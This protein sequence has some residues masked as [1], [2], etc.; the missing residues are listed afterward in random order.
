VGKIG[1]NANAAR[2]EIILAFQNRRGSFSRDAQLRL[3]DMIIFRKAWPDEIDRA[4]RICPERAKADHCFVAVDDSPVERIIGAAFWAVA[5]VS[6]QRTGATAQVEIAEFV[7]RMLPAHGGSAMERQ[8]LH[9]LKGE[10]HERCGA[11][12][13]KTRGMLRPDSPLA[14]SLMAAGFEVSATTTVFEGTIASARRGY[15]RMQKSFGQADRS[16]FTVGEPQPMHAAALGDLISRREGLM[17][18]EAIEQALRNPL[19]ESR[20]FDLDW[21]TVLL[22]SPSQRL[23]GAHLVKKTGQTM[24]V[25]AFAVGPVPLHLSGLSLFLML[26]RWLGLCEAHNWT[27]NFFC[28]INPARNPAMLRIGSLFDYREIGR[29]DS[30]A[31]GLPAGRK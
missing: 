22:D 11:A 29:Q 24:A 3:G 30:Y 6:E 9:A 12:T 8:F 17:Q 2:A 28:R 19:S 26:E 5:V 10:V 7:W 20:A 18:I 21:S 1:G 23:I 16:I 15:E 31:A 27:R 13:L 4:T 25:P 14:P